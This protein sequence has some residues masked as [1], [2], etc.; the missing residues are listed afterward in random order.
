MRTI[1]NLVAM[2]FFGI[3]PALAHPSGSAHLHSHDIVRATLGMDAVLVAVIVAFIASAAAL[4]VA[5]E[6]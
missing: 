1:T 2:A 5:R 6:R 4:A 3:T